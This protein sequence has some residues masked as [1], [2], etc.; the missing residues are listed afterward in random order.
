MNENKAL[1]AIGFYSFTALIDMKL[2]PGALYIHSASEPYNEEQEISQRRINNW[3]KH[4]G[5]EKFQCH[6][7]GHAGGKELLNAV[8]EI[9]AKTVYPIHTEHP[10]VFERISNSVL[11]QEGKRYEIS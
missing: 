2:K 9:N 10:K 5:I 1:C 8:V 6:C 7:S 11:I 4:F 3:L